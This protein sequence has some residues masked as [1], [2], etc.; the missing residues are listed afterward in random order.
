[1]MGRCERRGRYGE[2][3]C[4]AVGEAYGARGLRKV[5]M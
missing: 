3:G 2:G 1:M 4:Q 5:G